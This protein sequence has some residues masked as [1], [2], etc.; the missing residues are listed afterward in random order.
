MFKVNIIQDIFDTK[1][2]DKRHGDNFS[3]N[4]CCP[5]YGTICNH[6]PDDEI[7]DEDLKTI[8]NELFE[9]S[10]NKQVGMTLDLQGKV[11]SGSNEDKAPK[12]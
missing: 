1:V 8:S 3:H 10:I 11:P 6:D 9:L 7:T 4:D 5:D 2:N 12:K